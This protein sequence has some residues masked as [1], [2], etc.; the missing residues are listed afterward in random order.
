MLRSAD[1]EAQDIAEGFLVSEEEAEPGEWAAWG[2][3]PLIK[4]PAEIV[5]EL[6]WLLGLTGPIVL[7]GD[8]IDTVIAQ[9]T[10]ADPADPAAIPGAAGGRGGGRAADRARHLLAEEIGDGLMELREKP[11][12]TLIVVSC[13][14]RT[15][16][17][18]QNRA[19]DSV[20]DRFHADRRLERIPSPETAR[21][22][23]S[24][25]FAPRFARAEFTPPHPT[26]PVHPDALA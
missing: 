11:R 25:R 15:W 9:N 7:A 4:R 6:S 18:I 2:R 12:R 17:L 24:A 23:V 19:V 1:A 5:T 13:L 21:E 10:E 26:W 16:E 3:R 22:L 14:V 20:A 8:Q